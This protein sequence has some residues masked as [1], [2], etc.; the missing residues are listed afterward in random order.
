MPHARI[1]VVEDDEPIRRGIADALDY[2]GYAVL[3]APD[4]RAGLD[5]ACSQ[6]IDLVLLD[7]MMPKLNGF[8]MLEQL[9]RAKPGLPVIF[10]TARGEP[11]DKISGLKL[12]ADDY[13]VKPFNADELLARVEAV[14]RRSAERPRTLGIIEAPGLRIDLERRRVTH[15]DGTTTDLSEREAEVLG[16]L[17]ASPGRVVSRDELLQRVW[18][19]DPRGVQSRTV[20]MAIARLREQL[21][22]DPANPRVIRTVR[23]KGYAFADD[24][25]R[26]ESPEPTREG[27]G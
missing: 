6:D 18:G 16:Y 26:S 14:L 10:L 12:G 22:D 20:D 2:N 19:I 15:A 9:R 4:G 23:A 11:S 8:E 3:E 13:V 24:A 27:S 17:A 7:I 5:A 21:R 25:A 1:L